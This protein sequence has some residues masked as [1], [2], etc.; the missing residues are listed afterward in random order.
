MT[1]RWTI[2]FYRC[3]LSTDPIYSTGLFPTGTICVAA[4][5]RELAICWAE[6]SGRQKGVVALACY[7]DFALVFASFRLPPWHSAPGTSQAADSAP[8][9]WNLIQRY[10]TDCHNVTDWAGGVAFDSMSPDEI[11]TDAKVWEDAVRKLQGGFMP[12]PGAK[13][14]PDQ[15]AVTELVSWLEGSSTAT[16]ARLPAAHSCAV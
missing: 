12:P 7:A 3:S 13:Q 11:P 5:S 1:C 8:E 10:C 6:S 9:Q 16:R 14:H 2:G 4:A 15:H